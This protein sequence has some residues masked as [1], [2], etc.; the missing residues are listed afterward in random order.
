MVSMMKD[1]SMRLSAE[2]ASDT[3]AIR[4]EAAKEAGLPILDITDMRI[5]RKSIDARRNPPM[6][7]VQ[8][9]LY[10]DTDAEALYEKTIFPF[11]GDAKQVVIVGAGPA[12]L[13]T[14]LRLIELGLKPIILERGVGVEDRK[15]DIA[16]LAAHNIL[17]SESNFCFGEGG[18]G[19][20]SDGKLFVRTSKKDEVSPILALL[21]QHGASEDIFYEARPHLGS[22]TLPTIVSSIRSTIL[23]SGGEIHFSSKVVA[24]LREGNTVV[25][26]RTQNGDVYDGPVILATG[27]NARDMYEYLE[28]EQIDIEAKAL[29]VGVQVE[30]P[31]TLI[32]QIQYKT[33]EGRG[34][35]LPPA[36]YSFSAHIEGRSVYTLNMCPGGFV[37][38]V[39]H[40]S[41]T[42]SVHGI[43]NAK[44]NGK[45]A[46]SS[47]VVELQPQ[48]LPQD[49]F[50]GNLGVMH[51]QQALE[52][53]LC[54]AGGANHVA[55][56]QRMADFVN[57]RQSK[58][59]PDSS[60]SPGLVPADFNRI[61]PAFLASRLSTAF[62]IFGRK[63]HIFLTN[64]ASIIGGATRTSSPVRILRDKESG[65]HVKLEGLFPC[66]E[67]SGYAAGMVGS[68]LDG[69][70]SAQNVCSYLA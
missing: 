26:V 10:T 57:K 70:Q 3:R 60:Y 63:A 13:F 16:S 50:G 61:L 18:A 30:H 56:A 29:A 45:F 7:E 8:V 47:I 44:R 31:Q 58:T 68:A 38:P 55:P 54:K 64:Q 15:K 34:E 40:E 17:Q 12:G 5:L 41:G 52:E 36:E 59:L 1:I 24:L 2:T 39:M 69:R 6:V 49:Q 53:R 19:A 27:Q 37:V 51:F 35:F 32:D 48:D 28:E 14:A 67:G 21:C 20:F 25:G 46:N 33:N 65:M 43:S 23:D 42:L 62:A 9:R 66:G 4:R 11:V 22:D